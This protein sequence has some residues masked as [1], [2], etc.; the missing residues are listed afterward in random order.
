M[1]NTYKVYA[2]INKIND[3][4]YIGQTKYTLKKRYQKTGYRGCR[5]FYNAIQKYGWENFDHIVLVENLSLEM[6]NIIEEELIKKYNTTNHNVGYNIAFGG[7]NKRQS[8]ETIK[9]RVE[10][11]KGIKRNPLTDEQRRNISIGRTGVKVKPFTQEHRNKMSKS[12]LASKNPMYGKHMSDYTKEKLKEHYNNVFQYN[13]DGTFIRE[14]KCASDASSELGVD[15]SNISRCCNNITKTSNGYIW[16]YEKDV[17]DKND[18]CIENEKPKIFQYNKN[19]EYVAKFN[20]VRE[21]FE[22]TGIK[23][24]GIRGCLS[25]RLKSSGGYMWSYNNNQQIDSL[26]TDYY[27]GIKKGVIMLDNHSNYIKEFA[28][29]ADASCETKIDRAS[30]G[31]CCTGKSITAGGYK[32]A[33]KNNYIT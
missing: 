4:I 19:G 22:L 18:I 5:Y 10:K 9:R 8:E 26:F 24:T 2:H 3:K 28:S 32:W 29:I 21:A 13:I 31:R 7:L 14:W 15:V 23:K 33:Y 17:Q 25:G 20:S 12:K 27:N 1:E 6:S 30:I 16:R 11:I